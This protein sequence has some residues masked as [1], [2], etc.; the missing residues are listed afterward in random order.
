MIFVPFSEKCHISSNILNQIWV[1]SPLYKLQQQ[2]PTNQN[3]SNPIW[4]HVLLCYY[5]FLMH[6]DYFARSTMSATLEGSTCVIGG[7]WEIFRGTQKIE[8]FQISFYPDSLLLAI[9]FFY[10]IDLLYVTSNWKN[11]NFRENT[12]LM[13]I[14]EASNSK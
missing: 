10:S 12:L 13:L 8:I 9:H 3:A 14:R 7:F 6:H 2:Q 1:P 5:R 4:C 11:V